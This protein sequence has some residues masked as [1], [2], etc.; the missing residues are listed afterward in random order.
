MR[1]APFLPVLLDLWLFLSCSSTLDNFVQASVGTCSHTCQIPC[2]VA[3]SPHSCFSCGCLFAG[4]T[5]GA[6][7]LLHHIFLFSVD[8]GLYPFGGLQMFVESGAGEEV[9]FLWA[10]C[11]HARQAC[12]FTSTG[13]NSGG[14]GSDGWF[15]LVNAVPNTL[16]S[17]VRTAAMCQD[18]VSFRHSVCTM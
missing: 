18:K 12:G 1:I 2:S 8:I 7:V 5:G 3:R 15:I 6:L 13:N 9:A 11:P 4:G 17:G 10:S 16:P 14:K